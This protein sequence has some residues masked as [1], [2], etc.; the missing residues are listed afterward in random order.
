MEAA[1]KAEV[2]GRSEAPPAEITPSNVVEMFSMAID[3]LSG[4]NAEGVVNALDRLQTLHERM[5]DR[6]AEKAFNTALAR[7]Q[8]DCPVIAKTSTA[9]VTSK[10]TGSTFT[11]SYAELDEIIKTAGPYLTRNGFAWTWDS[12]R[13]DA[14]LETICVLRH[15]AGH[16][17]Q[18]RFVAPVESND[19]MSG[20]QHGAAALTFGKR[21]SFIQVTG[22]AVGDPDTDGAMQ[23]RGGDGAPQLITPEQAADLRAA[24]TELQG[25]QEAPFLGMLGVDCVESIRAR[26]YRR[27][28]A[29]IEKKRESQ[30]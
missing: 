5:E 15:E 28:M 21:Q 17:A 20:A 2:V 29:A 10:R 22:L 23:S 4:D 25:D 14:G 13:T 3:K 16:V 24:L 26:D 27:A 1:K 11:Y 30:A 19:R 9:K 12:S 8:A 18:S 7:F 6:A